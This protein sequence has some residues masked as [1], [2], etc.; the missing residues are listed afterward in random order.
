VSKIEFVVFNA[1]VAVVFTFAIAFNTV[2][3]KLELFDI[4][5][6]NSYNVSK[7][8]GAAPTKLATAVLT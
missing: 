4:A 5:F 2:V 8:A 7:E 6:A 3:E 1:V